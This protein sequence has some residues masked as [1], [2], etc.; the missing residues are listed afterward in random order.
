MTAAF[1]RL[2]KLDSRLREMHQDGSLKTLPFHQRSSLFKS[3]KRCLK[4]LLT[5]DHPFTKA[6][7]VFA[8][9]MLLYSHTE[10]QV[11]CKKFRDAFESNPLKRVPLPHNLL[12]PAFVDIDADG[13]LDC[14][15]IYREPDQNNYTYDSIRF[16][17]IRNTGSGTLPV[18]EPAGTGGFPANPDAVYYTGYLQEGPV[19]ADIDGDGDY[20]CFLASYTSV[21][22][23]FAVEY[24]ENTGDKHN[25]VFVQ[26]PRNQHPLSFVTGYGAL[27]F[28]L[29]DI[30]GD[31]DMDLVTFESFADKFY[32]NKGTKNNPDF[33][34][35][36]DD[37]NGGFYN[38]YLNH[39]VFLDWNKDG[40][41]DEIPLGGG[42]FYTYV[43]KG[44]GHHFMTSNYVDAPKFTGSVQNY[45][46]VDLN[47][48]GFLEAFNETLDYAV[49]SPVATIKATANRLDAYPKHP[50]FKY[51]WL[52]DRVV[53]QNATS[54]FIEVS[55]SGEYIVEITGNCGTGISLPYSVTVNTAG[56][57]LPA[58]EDLSASTKTAQLQL[59]PNPFTA[60]CVLQLNKEITGNVMIHITDVQGRRVTSLKA[61]TNTVRFGK[62][63]APGIYFIQVMNGSE[64]IFHQKLVKQ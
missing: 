52:K 41:I 39:Y 9:S 47:N 2:Q 33:V 27:F 48:D 32:L 46:M 53:I 4:K 14:Y 12:L 51:Q 23:N 5:A 1:C 36:R 40:L 63:L 6:V 31:G 55:Q 35:I 59:Y 34:F 19:F 11:T 18:F 44:E 38:P 24:F 49:M 21:F 15:S 7:G 62:Q 28:N 17:F 45:A 50:S 13:D 25:P 54:S 43:G 10:A 58:K 60:E 37:R 22:Y 29:A 8:I 57:S 61:N 16:S 56:A 30:D 64:M 3:Y 20:D 26:R 42:R